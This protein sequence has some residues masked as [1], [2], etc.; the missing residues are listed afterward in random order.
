MTASER[1]VVTQPKGN[2][3]SLSLVVLGAITGVAV[4]GIAIGIPSG[5]PFAFVG[6]GA[7]GWFTLRAGRVAAVADASGLRVRN[8]FDTHGLEWAD[9]ARVSV[10]PRTGGGGWGIVV[11]RC[12]ATAVAI[13][14]SWG[15][16]YAS[17]G[18]L[19]K[20]NRRRCE[21]LVDRIEALRPRTDTR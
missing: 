7:L 14:A 16:W 21:G 6:L 10:E 11:T 13:E 15:P 19:A 17:R 1:V 9:V 20:R 8:L 12:D 2:L 5:A 18:P 4:L 3:V